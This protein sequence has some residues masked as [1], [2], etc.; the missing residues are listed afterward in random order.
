MRKVGEDVT[1]VLD[2]VPGHFEVIK[3]IRPAFSC[4]RCESM[5]QMPMPSL[6]I[7]RGRPSPGLLAHILVSKYCDHTPLYRQ[8]GIYAR[9]AGSE[10]VAFAS[11]KRNG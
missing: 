4:R 10:D 9:A 1:E 6:P 3:H 8:A 2:Y 5:V 11:L 7:E